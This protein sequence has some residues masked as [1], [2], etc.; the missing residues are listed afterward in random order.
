MIRYSLYLTVRK[1]DSVLVSSCRTEKRGLVW[2]WFDTAYVDA[3]HCVVTNSNTDGTIGMHLGDS[4][5]SAVCGLELIGEGQH[6]FLH[7]LLPYLEVMIYA[8]GVGF[9]Q[10][11]IYQLLP[12][13]LN[14]YHVSCNRYVEEHVSMKCDCTRRIIHEGLIG[15]TSSCVHGGCQCLIHKFLCL[16]HRMGFVQMD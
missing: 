1:L 15:G 9:K 7:D 8:F 11:L 13:G 5:R 10:S 6:V 12:I 3:F 4:I 16:V 2:D 14:S